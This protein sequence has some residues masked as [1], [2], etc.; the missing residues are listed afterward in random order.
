MNRRSFLQ[1]AAALTVTSALPA[2]ASARL[3]IRMA[4][5]YNML[6]ENLSILQRFQLA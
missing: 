5:E 3:P 4:V 2:R 1:T 6:P